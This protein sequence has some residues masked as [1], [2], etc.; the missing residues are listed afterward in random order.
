LEKI[1]DA[2]INSF[3]ENRVGITQQFLSEELASHLKVNL[4]RLYKNEVFKQAG[5]GNDM[6]VVRDQLV[7]SD[8][9][10]W[11]DRKHNDAT[12]NVFFDLMDEFV[13]YLN[14]EC[15][16]G[17]CGYEFHYTRYE[18]GSFYKKHIDQFQKHGNR[19]YSMVMYL[20][21]NWE[22]ADGGEL[23]IHHPHEKQ[24]ISP[25]NRRAVFFKSS[26]LAHEVMTTQ[27]PRLSITGWFKTS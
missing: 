22:I 5:T 11:L 25:L 13:V 14:K 9:I 8:E 12:E 21:E 18:K 1:F 4:Q 7:R 3:V 16:T 24:L 17:I 15:F 20:N 6:L 19:A 26:E 27:V 23:C 2:L 10:Y